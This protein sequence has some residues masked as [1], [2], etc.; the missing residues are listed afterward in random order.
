VAHRLA[1]H[2]RHDRSN[3]EWYFTGY[4]SWDAFEK[5]TNAKE[6]AQVL[7]DTKNC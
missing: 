2:H 1:G 6:A 3:E 7:A 4:P 5:D